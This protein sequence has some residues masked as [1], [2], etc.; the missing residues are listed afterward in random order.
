MIEAK[1]TENPEDIK[2]DDVAPQDGD[3]EGGAGQDVDD[4]Q[5]EGA[6]AP[7]WHA[8]ELPED[9]M[10]GKY[11]NMGEVEK[12]LKHSSKMAR[13]KGLDRDA[14]EEYAFDFSGVEGFED[15]EVD[16]EDPTL[17]AMLP[18]FKEVSLPQAEADRL[19]QAFLKHQ[20]ESDAANIEA[21]RKEL[22]D[23]GKE[24]LDRITGFVDKHFTPEEAAAV[25]L[26]GKTAAGIRV[27]DKF[28][29]MQGMKNVPIGDSGS[30]G[31]SHDEIIDKIDK[32][33]KD[34]DLNFNK[35]KQDQYEKLLAEDVKLKS[36]R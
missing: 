31:L 17:Q 12:A 2:N 24:M 14:P 33:R 3:P 34:P 7:E 35:A 25:N 22:G 8:Q 16:M 9:F 36:K 19:V 18:A 1:G 13:E 4:N 15:I 5:E 30:P 10:G 21:Q 11:K 32:L 28:I 20:L 29:Q 6:D 27:L 26:I 23:E